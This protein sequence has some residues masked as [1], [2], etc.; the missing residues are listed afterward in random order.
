MCRLTAASTLVRLAQGLWC[1]AAGGCG[2]ET[3][4]GA[5]ARLLLLNLNQ[6]Q[7]FLLM[8]PPGIFRSGEANC[9]AVCVCVCVCVYVHLH[10]RILS[11]HCGLD[12]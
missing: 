3:C 8:T 4:D 2:I 1:R 6:V 11:R 10:D 12:L 9:E 7:M 5:A